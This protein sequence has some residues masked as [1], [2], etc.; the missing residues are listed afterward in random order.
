MG[1]WVA[2]PQG[3]VAATRDDDIVI[4][5]VSGGCVEEASVER[6]TQG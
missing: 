4:G 3:T 1:A 5:S 2:R 6:L